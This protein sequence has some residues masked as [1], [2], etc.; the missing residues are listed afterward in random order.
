MELFSSNKLAI[1]EQ[2]FAT[3]LEEKIRKDNAGESPDERF[4]QLS[5]SENAVKFFHI[6]A[7]D[8]SEEQKEDPKVSIE[9]IKTGE[10]LAAAKAQPASTTASIVAVV[11]IKG[12]MQ[13]RASYWYLSASTVNAA[14]YIQMLDADPD[15]KGI[16]LDIDSPGGTVSGTYELAKVIKGTKKPI[17]AYANDL[18]ASA[19]M[20][21]A[22]QADEIWSSSPTATLGSIDVLS[23]HD[24]YSEMFREYGI[25][26]TYIT[27]DE[28]KDKVVGN[29]TEPLTE[30]AYKKI[31]AELK[32]IKVVFEGSVRKG[33]GDRLQENERTFSGA[34]YHSKEAKDVG[35]LDGMGDMNRV[36]SR[37][38]SLYRQFKRDGVFEDG[39][40]KSS[41]TTSTQSQKVN[42]NMNIFA[43]FL[44]KPEQVVQEDITLSAQDAN[45]LYSK[46]ATLTESDAKL[47]AQIDNLKAQLEGKE[48]ALSAVENE[49]AELASSVSSLEEKVEA[50]N[51]QVAD[52]TEKLEE[53]NAKAEGLATEVA[54][55]KAASEKASA[56]LEEANAKLEEANTNL[57]STQ[58]A[59][60][61]VTADYNELAKEAGKEVKEVVKAST[62][63]DEEPKVEVNSARKTKSIFSVRS[64]TVNISAIRN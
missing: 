30:E 40:K 17:V 3:L 33:R 7:E 39:S 41:K 50:A 27:S 6:V 31:E 9:L 58:T 21:I 10:E 53:A 43:K 61:K 47:N 18:C 22:S 48:S 25:K 37:V 13:K 8:I 55:A 60:G 23:V 34:T 24:D 1:E 14:Q 16:I 15:I 63:E 20:W 49:K 45:D 5:E 36:V 59:L 52:L 11:P 35:I 46:L 32:E 38:N 19:A 57:T 64:N 54:E 56:D 51:A 28:S 26:R 2:F 12:V 44:G 29:P 42:T 4:F 62:E